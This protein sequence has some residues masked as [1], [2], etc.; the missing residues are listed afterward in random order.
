MKKPAMIKSKRWA[1][2]ALHQLMIEGEIH[3]FWIPDHKDEWKIRKTDKSK[4]R[5]FTWA[6]IKEWLAERGYEQP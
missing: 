5:T 2:T 4:W 1:T 3:T 6:E